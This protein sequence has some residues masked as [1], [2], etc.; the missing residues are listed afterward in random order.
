GGAATD[1]SSPS[2]SIRVKEVDRLG[3]K[4]IRV[5]A[6]RRNPGVQD[7]AKTLPAP[8]RMTSAEGEKPEALL[9]GESRPVG[10]AAVKSD[11]AAHR[12]DSR[13]KESA[14]PQGVGA[15]QV[16]G[17]ALGAIQTHAS[18]T[19]YPGRIV[20]TPP[21][22]TSPLLQSDATPLHPAAGFAPGE[23]GRVTGTPTALE[24]G[25]HG[26]SH[27]WLTVRAEL[28]RDGS[29]HASMSSNSA[30]G[31][32]ALQREVPQLTSYLHQ[33]QVHVSSV[34]IHAAQSPTQIS[35]QP[36]NEGR[37]QSM[38]GGSP[39]ANRSDSEV[40]MRHAILE[41]TCISRAHRRMLTEMCCCPGHLDR[42]VAG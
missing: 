8:H 20:S 10:E 37:G 6:L 21:T 17:G 14:S 13:D 22:H 2:G 1:F 32:E 31:T 34:V 42:R 36:S 9:S 35:N 30:A 7:V 16:S 23:H 38:D 15:Q 39:D 26:G 12:S 19:L 27:G 18:A 29:V 3:S 4:R 25:V 5:D 40:A 24:V 41:R 33:E 28:G 11:P